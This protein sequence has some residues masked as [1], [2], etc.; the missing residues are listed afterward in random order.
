MRHLTDAFEK[1]GRIEDS[2]NSDVGLSD[3]SRHSHGDQALPKTYRAIN[4][5]LPDEFFKPDDKGMISFLEYGFS[6]TSDSKEVIETFRDASAF[7]LTLEVTQIK[8]EITGCHQGVPLEWLT[9]YPGEREI[10][11]PPLTMFQVLDKKREGFNIYLKV[12]PFYN[13]Q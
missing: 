6:S 4:G 13:F 1:L 11:F 3:D 9:Y 7:N 2:K 10:L 8:N 5:I 12:I